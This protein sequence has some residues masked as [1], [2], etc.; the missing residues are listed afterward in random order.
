LKSIV[1]YKSKTGF[2]RKYAEWIARGLSADVISVKKLKSKNLKD[3]DNIIYGGSLFAISI[4]GFKSFKKRMYKLTNKKIAVFV[5]GAS[6]ISEEVEE[7]IKTNN[8]TNEE[9]ER[10]KIFYFRG[11]F[12]YKKLRLFDKMLVNLL[13]LD[14]KIKVKKGIILSANEEMMLEL[15]HGDHDYTD[16]EAIVPLIDY[17]RP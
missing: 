11:G 5:C 12:N 7:V 10:T 4:T 8:F 9:L 2:V 6:P 3:Y 17:I 14:I 15:F 13:K 16:I 1:I